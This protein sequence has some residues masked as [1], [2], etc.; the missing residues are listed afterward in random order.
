M[1]QTIQTD[2]NPWLKLP[3][4][5]PFILP[6]D[7]PILNKYKT[8]LR[9]EGFPLPYFGSLERAKVMLLLLNP[10]FNQAYLDNSLSDYN[11]MILSRF[12][13][14]HRTT[15]FYLDERLN[16]TGG[17]KWWN[18]MTKPLV[19]G[20][21]PKNILAEQMMV[22]QYLGYHSETYKHL[23]ERLPSQEY[24]FGLVREAIEKGLPIV[25]MRSERLWL[26]AVPELTDHGYMKTR[27]VRNPVLSRNNLGDSDY[28]TL[29]ASFLL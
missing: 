10:G 23:P 25:I 15:L 24:S 26:E 12:N 11:Y 18:R 13:L 5:P 27:N 2:L 1:G 9:F 29:K 22:V 16:F 3:N 6:K 14:V 17:Y 19:E 4:K 28:E 20:G 7:E 8:N 21:V